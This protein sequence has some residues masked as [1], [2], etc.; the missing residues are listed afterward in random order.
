[1]DGGTR[2]CELV[3]RGTHP[4]AVI[5]LFSNALA[6]KAERAVF[7]HRHSAASSVPLPVS[8]SVLGMFG[9]GRYDM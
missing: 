7:N 6:L 8:S 9:I 3:D 1:M 4:L 5:D 2:K